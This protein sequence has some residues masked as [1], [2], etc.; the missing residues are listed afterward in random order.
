MTKCPL[1]ECGI[2]FKNRRLAIAHYRSNH[3]TTSALC[4]LCSKPISTKFGANNY[5]THFK[6]V[7]PHAKLSQAQLKKIELSVQNSQKLGAPS[8]QPVK[9]SIATQSIHSK[10]SCR[11]CG[12]QCT[13]LSRHM[14][15]MHTKK[16]I[17]CPLKSC[18]YTSKRLE[19]IR[20][21]WKRKHQQFRFPEISRDSGFTY[22]TTTDDTQKSVRI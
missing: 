9:H 2:K 18:D 19:F 20:E 13:H 21:H 6:R 15:E 14:M 11:V 1:L 22:R 12:K 8:K 3:A 16:R 17:L 10:N 7:H 4:F 5:V